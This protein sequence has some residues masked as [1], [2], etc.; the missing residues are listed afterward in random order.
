[1]WPKRDGFRDVIAQR[2]SFD[3]KP[4]SFDRTVSGGARLRAMVLST[5][6]RG[7]A[8]GRHKAQTVA[9]FEVK[10]TMSPGP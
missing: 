2:T 4:P 8:R 6:L 3:I 7:K 9:L 5:P 10:T 1:M